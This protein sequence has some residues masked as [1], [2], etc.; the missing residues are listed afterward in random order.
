ME[1]RLR[2]SGSGYKICVQ[3]VPVLVL[4]VFACVC[5]ARES[6]GGVRIAALTAPLVRPSCLLTE[7]YCL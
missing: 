4:S 5:F 7:G 6:V 1:G 2:C 3:L